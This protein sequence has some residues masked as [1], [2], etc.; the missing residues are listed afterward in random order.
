MDESAEGSNSM[1]QLILASSSIYRKQLL[2]RLG[3]AFTST[4]PD[5]DE[6]PKTQERPKDLVKRLSF[7]KAND[8]AKAHPSAFVIGSDQIAIFEGQIIGK[9]INYATA[10]KQLSH[11]SGQEI[12]FLTGISLI[13]MEKDINDYQLSKVLVKFRRL[14]ELEITHYLNLD[15]PFDCAGSFKIEANG[16]RLFE[17]VKSDDPS[18]LEGLPLLTVNRM[19]IDSGF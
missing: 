1:S 17:T 5:I 12:E 4:R 3:Y 8:V 13:C 14:S 19:L 7:E 9:P 6:T 15:K 11:F 18:S 10:K 2:Q 16:I